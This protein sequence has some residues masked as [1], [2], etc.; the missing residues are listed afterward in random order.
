MRTGWK[1]AS[2]MTVLAAGLAALTVPGALYAQVA[3]PELTPFSFVTV[4]PAAM[5]WGKPSRIGAA[6]TKAE[7]VTDPATTTDKFEGGAAGLRLVERQFSGAI[8][9][10]RLDSTSKPYGQTEYDEVVRAALALS[11]GKQISLGIGQTNE[12]TET[13]GGFG[14]VRDTIE[15]PLY[16]L[17]LR[18]GEGFFLGGAGGKE[19]VKHVDLTFSRA[20]YTTTRDAYMYGAGIRTAG[21]YVQAHFEYYVVDRGNYAESR[22]TGG[23]E[24]SR[25]GVAELGFSDFLIGY[26]GTHT[27]RESGFPVTDESRVDIGFVPQ[28]GF[29]LL[30]RGRFTRDTYPAGSFIS[31]RNTAA[32]TIAI[33]YQFRG[34]GF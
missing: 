24:N 17:T 3:A 32:Y 34:F 16:G 4:N 15:T 2:A 19:S 6:Y 8:D 21:E 22:L 31:S 12:Q 9:Y 7:L 30:G 27:E 20:N 1:T 23:R 33:V 29:S 26:A 18:F 13:I 10:S 25:T 5:Q 28:R 14:P 11:L